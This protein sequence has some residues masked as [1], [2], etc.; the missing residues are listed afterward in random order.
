MA[1]RT[2]TERARQGQVFVG[3]PADRTAP[4]ASVTVNGSTAPFT[5]TPNGINLDAPVNQ[6]DL[7]VVTFTTQY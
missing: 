7:I 6:N 1:T 3:L 5:S 4:V 2:L